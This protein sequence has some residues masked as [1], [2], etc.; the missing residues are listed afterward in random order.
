MQRAVEK[1]N[2]NRAARRGKK[3]AVFQKVFYAAE[4]AFRD[5]QLSNKTARDNAK[6]YFG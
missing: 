2:K 1:A 5:I 3:Q 4:N 6:R